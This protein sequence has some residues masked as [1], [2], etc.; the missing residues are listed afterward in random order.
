MKSD[1]E[2]KLLKPF[3]FTFFKAIKLMMFAF[4]FSSLGLSFVAY[5]MNIAISDVT[6]Q[7]SRK[8]SLDF[9]SLSRLYK[10]DKNYEQYLVNCYSVPSAIYYRRLGAADLSLKSVELIKVKAQ[11]K[12]L[13]SSTYLL[14]YKSIED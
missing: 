8:L 5:K 14:R 9:Q 11:K 13:S 2:R 10:L 3:G 6:E 12:K 7:V 4:V 1:K